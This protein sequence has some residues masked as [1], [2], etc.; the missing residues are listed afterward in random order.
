MIKTLKELCIKKVLKNEIIYH[1]TK[2]DTWPLYCR[3]TDFIGNVNDSCWNYC[4]C[5]FV[6]KNILCEICRFDRDLSIFYESELDKQ[7]KL[8]KPPKHYNAVST[9]ISIFM[10]NRLLEQYEA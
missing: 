1:C 5:R 3:V 2:I 8:K 10:Y 6:G 4:T 9:A 7:N